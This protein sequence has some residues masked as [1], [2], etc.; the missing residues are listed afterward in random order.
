MPVRGSQPSGWRALLAGEL[1]R[2]D[3]PPCLEEG[4][5]E[6]YQACARKQLACADFWV[7]ARNMDPRNSLL[8]GRL[9]SKWMY[10]RVFS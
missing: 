5:C 1:Y 3:L 10:E 9:P 8:S 4:K 7:Y 6:H 2:L